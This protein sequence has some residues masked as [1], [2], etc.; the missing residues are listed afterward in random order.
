MIEKI[1]RSLTVKYTA[2]IAC[3]L[4]LGFAVSYTAYRHNS[5]RLLQDTLY[6]YLTEELWEAEEFIRRGIEEYDVHQINSDIKSLH[7]FTYWFVDKKIVRA[8]RPIDEAISGQLEQRFLDKNYKN[9]KIYHENIKHNKQK[10]YFIVVKQ[11]LP[12]NVVKNGKVFVLANYTPIRKNTKAYVKIALAAALMMLLLAYFVSNFFVSRSMKYIERNYQKQKQFVSD[13]AHELRTPLTILY[14]YAEL[15]EYN[16]RKKEIIEDVKDEIQQM[17]GMVDRLLAIARYDNSKII[18]HKEKV[19]VNEI[20]AAVIKPMA[21]LY[22]SGR[23]VISAEDENVEIEAD[24]V[25]LQQLLSIL[26]DNAAKY[27]SE[28]KKISVEIVKRPTTVVI[29]VKDNGIGIK[30]EDLCRIFD[31]FWRAEESRHQKGLGLGL[32]LADTIVKLHKGIINVQ[33]EFGSGSV[34]E[35][36]LPQK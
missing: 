26:L 27:T 22:P 10:W 6:D 32:S 36:V 35:I 30:K 31:R 29:R 4:F 33:S 15:L 8:E 1:R 2:V 3:V 9:G 18:V 19:V 34:F 12:P 21:A 11:D 20:V 7:N 13:A 16:P 17:S 14:S 23:F 25:M 24:K 5:I 28:N